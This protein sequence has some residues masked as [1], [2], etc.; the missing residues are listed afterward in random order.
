MDN[1]Y[2]ITSGSQQMES[3][4]GNKFKTKPYNLNTNNNVFKP[5]KEVSV[6]FGTDSYKYRKEIRNEFEFRSSSR[7]F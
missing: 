2:H 7:I 6:T 3:A 1:I 5:N 4:N